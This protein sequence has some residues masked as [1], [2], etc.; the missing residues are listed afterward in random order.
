M[1]NGVSQI[2]ADSFDHAGPELE[3]D[4][5]VQLLNGLTYDLLTPDV[6]AGEPMEP[7]A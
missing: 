7:A 2:S 1:L 4:G 3:D 5:F 6:W